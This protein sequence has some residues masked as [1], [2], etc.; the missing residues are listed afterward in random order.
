[1]LNRFLFIICGLALLTGCQQQPAADPLAY[2]PD[3]ETIA[4]TDLSGVAQAK[5][6]DF[7]SRA[8]AATG[9]Y[10]AWLNTKKLEL[11][12]VVTFYNSDGSFYLTQ[13]HHEIYPWSNS[14]RISAVEP[15][16]KFTWLLSQDN[17]TPAQAQIQYDIRNAIYAVQ[18]ITM[19]PVRFLDKSAEFSKRS[20]PVKM[21]GLWYY[22]IR[23]SRVRSDERR[24][25]VFYQSRDT[26]LIDI[27]RFTSPGH[28]V[29][30]SEAQPSV[31]IPISLMVRGYDYRKV[32]ATGLLLPTK[33]EIFETN[34]A[35]VI[36]H[37]LLKIEYH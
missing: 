14:I 27:T 4:V 5:S 26:S 22:P 20:E 37:R 7:I 19:A 13:Q 15:Q 32:K 33:I 18:D 35:G 1:M 9:G 23:C 10:E 36:Q 16:G 34:P 8:I 21:E 31:A 2:G 28:S 30:A 24:E 6:D 17:F 29:I 25:T 3:I 12:C 11:D